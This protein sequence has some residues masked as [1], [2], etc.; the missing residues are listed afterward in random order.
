MIDCVIHS[1]WTR[2]RAI[3]LG[4]DANENIGLLKL[5]IRILQHIAIA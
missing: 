1:L 2:H 5:V 4:V 3:A